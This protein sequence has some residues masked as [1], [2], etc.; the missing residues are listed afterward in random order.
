MPSM[1]DLMT[2]YAPSAENVPSAPSMQD[3]MA[4]YSK[5][6]PKPDTSFVSNYGQ[7]FLNAAN[8]SRI[9]LEGL[10]QSVGK[11]LYGDNP[12]DASEQASRQA[13][14]AKIQSDT[15]QS[16]VVPSGVAGTLG[17]VAGGIAGS[18]TSWTPL[19]EISAIGDV[20]KGGAKVGGLTGLIQNTDDNSIWNHLLGAGE[21]AAEGATAAAVL[22]KTGQA[23][24][25]IPGGIV[26]RFKGALA[27]SAEDM[28]IQS[29]KNWDDASNLFKSSAQNGAIINDSSAQNILNKVKSAVGSLRSR[30]SATA[31]T[32]S[33]FEST[34]QKGN[35]SPADLHDF[36][37]DLNDVI[38][39]NTKSK[40]DGGGI[41]KDGQKAMAA[42]DALDEALS[43]LTGKDLSSGTPQAIEDLQNGINSTARAYR[44]DRVANMLKD[45][46][47]DPNTIMRGATRLL[48]NTNGLND[49]EVAA[50]NDLATRG[51]GQ[52]IERA[53]GTFGLDWGKTK[54]MALPVLTADAAKLGGGAYLPGGVPMVAAGTILRQ[55]GKWAAKGKGQNLLDTIMERETAPPIN[56][57]TPPPPPM[58]ALPAPKITNYVNSFGQNVPLSAADREIIGQSPSTAAERQPTASI[59]AAQQVREKFAPAFAQNEVV[60]QA[61]KKMQEDNLWQK[62]H[63][64]P[65]QLVQEAAQRF[66]DA[67]LS[68]GEVGNALIHFL[69][70]QQ[71]SMPLPRFSALMN[72]VK[73]FNPEKLISLA[74]ATAVANIPYQSYGRINNQAS[75]NTLVSQ[76]NAQPDV[77]NF[78]KAESNNNPNAKNPN[79]TASGEYQFTNRTWADMVAKYGKQTGIAIGDKNNPQAQATMA[80]FYAKDNISSLQKSLGRMPSK[81][82]LY[83]AH[84]LG[85]Q[86]AANLIKADPNQEAIMIFPRQVFDA[87]RQIFFDGSRPRRVSEVQNI[88]A[89]KVS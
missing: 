18:P 50:L 37:K 56:P 52:S 10:G 45:A 86:G 49:E 62:N 88:L 85:A 79:S 82:E 58:L 13:E 83:M 61:M 76:S 25:E 22:G 23:L 81:P 29:E 36:R 7:S 11:A 41:N 65:E 42:K 28:A 30:E 40:I 21:G 32:L 48:K 78:A 35:V 17:S 43:N 24:T 51:T 46:G 33:D 1:Q 59:T 4:K 53:L 6:Q 44:Y 2:Q 73:S 55:T 77:S 63:I 34:L 3:L 71:G 15:A 20:V 57:V 39:E 60:L 72:A 64:P 31:G 16:G 14:L 87:N 66:K 9:G 5:P 26:N 67:G 80:T 8:E 38:K 69:S 70:D 27:D 12:Q 54:N 47:G 84:V 68:M 74:P 75:Q 19:G 89:K